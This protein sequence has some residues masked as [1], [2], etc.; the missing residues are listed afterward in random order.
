M[1][2]QSNAG[3]GEDILW[4]V[5]AIATELR[6]PERAVYL[7]LSRRELPARL[8]NGKWCASRSA[9]RRHFAA[10]LGGEVA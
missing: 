4:G 5:R 10:L 7:M 8:L 9:L 6:R 2:E 1:T 3:V